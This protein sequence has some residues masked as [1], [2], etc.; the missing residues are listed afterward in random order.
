MNILNVDCEALAPNDY[1]P[2]NPTGPTVENYFYKYFGM[3][4]GT[5]E[6]TQENGGA[7][8]SCGED[9]VEMVILGFIICI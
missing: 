9:L 2:A 5:N 6:E 7:A 1:L 8:V 3:I 4:F